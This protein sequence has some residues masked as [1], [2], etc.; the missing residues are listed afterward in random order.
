M[1]SRAP[2]VTLRL[3]YR[4]AAKRGE[5]LLCKSIAE[6]TRGLDT[7]GAEVQ[8]AYGYALEHLG[9][10]DA[11]RRTY[12][13]VLML[14]HRHEKARARLRVLAINRPKPSTTGGGTGRARR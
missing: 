11:A 4:S 13:V 8:Y 5:W 7:N 14:D 3:A 1:K 2:L 9:Q 6:Q 12:E 10:H